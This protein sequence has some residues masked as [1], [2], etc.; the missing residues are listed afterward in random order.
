MSLL[1]DAI[2]NTKE[3]FSIADSEALSQEH[4]VI[5]KY[6]KIFSPSYIDDLQW[7][8]F[9]DFLSEDENHHWP[10]YERLGPQLEANFDKLKIA[11]K[12]LLDESKPIGERLKETVSDKGEFKVQNFGPAVATAILTVVFPKK[13]AVYNETVVKAMNSIQNE[14]KYSRDRNYFVQHYEEFNKYAND[15]AKQHGISLWELDWVWYYIIK[16]PGGN[17]DTSQN[18]SN[19]GSS[20]DIASNSDK[21]GTYNEDPDFPRNI[22]LYGPV[23]TGKTFLATRI[24]SGIIN[25]SGLTLQNLREWMK[26]PPSEETSKRKQ[27]KM[28]TMH[29][30]YGYEQ[31]VEGLRPQTTEN[32]AIY[33]DIQPG[34]FKDFSNK[35]KESLQNDKNAKYVLILDEINRADISRVFGELITL[36]EQ[37]KRE[38]SKEKPGMNVE[39]IYSHKQFSVPM[40]LYIIGTMNTTDKSIALM[41]LAIRRRFHFIPVE[42]DEKVLDKLLK[43]KGTP[44]DVK[45][46]VRHIFKVLNR[47]IAEFR[48]S[49]YGIGHAY[50]KDIGSAEDLMNSW[51]YKIMPLLQEYFYLDNDKLLEIL[52]FVIKIGEDKG[53]NAKENSAVKMIKKY[54]GFES[55][56]EFLEGVLAAK[57]QADSKK[58]DDEPV[59][60]EN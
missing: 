20:N 26:D 13:Y 31:F 43:D 45:E 7:K 52:K 58:V 15:L 2:K 49:D 23:G 12:I 59:D 32:G 21:I 34:T 47:E 25:E 8:K 33:Y 40:N 30:S 14:K 9:Q 48:G 54:H 3:R 11:L 5:D 42:P 36:L 28:I 55:P 60:A 6:S 18:G 44:D 4:E 16:H 27:I 53:N 51:N 17:P 46:A 56:G 57:N 37:D 22:V 10:H 1:E 24:A 19:I 50:F 38:Q 41:D 29:K 35:A 39:L